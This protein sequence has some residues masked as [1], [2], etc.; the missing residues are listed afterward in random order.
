MTCHTTQGTSLKG[1]LKRLR[2][3]KFIISHQHYTS[4]PVRTNDIMAD[5]DRDPANLEGVDIEMTSASADSVSTQPPLEQ[6]CSDASRTDERPI[7]TDLREERLGLATVVFALWLACPCVLAAYLK[8]YEYL[9]EDNVEV[10]A[11]TGDVNDTNTTVPL[12]RVQCSDEALNTTDGTRFDMPGG[13]C[14]IDLRWCFYVCFCMI[15]VRVAT[16]AL[17]RYGKAHTRITQFCLVVS[18]GLAIS[19]FTA[20]ILAEQSRGEDAEAFTFPVEGVQSNIPGVVLVAARINVVV[21]AAVSAAVLCSESESVFIY[22]NYILWLAL[23]IMS[24]IYPSVT[25]ALFSLEAYSYLAFYVVLEVIKV[26]CMFCVIRRYGSDIDHLLAPDGKWEALVR[27]TVGLCELCALCDFVAYSVAVLLL[28]PEE[29][30]HRFFYFDPV[31]M[32]MF[33]GVVLFLCF[34]Y[35]SQTTPKSQMAA[36]PKLENLIVRYSGRNIAHDMST[37]SEGYLTDEGDDVPAGEGEGMNVFVT[38][39]RREKVRVHVGV[40]DTLGDMCSKA[41]QA[42]LPHTTD[43]APVQVKLLVDG[44]ALEGDRNTPVANLPVE[45]GCNVEVRVRK[46]E[47][48]EDHFTN[49]R[50]AGI[51]C[52]YYGVVEKIV[53]GDLACDE[54]RRLVDECNT[55]PVGMWR[56]V[57]PF[58]GAPHFLTCV[59]IEHGC[60]VSDF[61]HVQRG[62][63]AMKVWKCV[64]VVMVVFMVALHA[65]RVVEYGS[66]NSGWVFLAFLVPASVAIAYDI[67]PPSLRAV[68]AAQ[69]KSTTVPLRPATHLLNTDLENPLLEHSCLAN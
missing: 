48:R 58:A 9:Y 69:K 51:D 1:F 36:W 3:T 44:C 43:S 40:D 17:L 49:G 27:D 46:N 65:T 64:Y 41:R 47:P 61:V 4:R 53:A 2:S 24:F 54:V 55:E 66:R 16:V 23:F 6:R 13:E 42:C 50:W 68:L 67:E 63:R 60:N 30:R 34:T 31:T 28:G 62:L 19:V 38:L 35:I 37:A 33:Q 5:P 59:L 11:L 21:S 57:L 25:K 12:W 8:D 14:S 10:S 18:D 29:E 32:S 56:Y 20:I 15:G 45:E 39:M 52:L 26:F 22:L 7:I